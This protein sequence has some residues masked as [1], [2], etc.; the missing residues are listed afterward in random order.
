M[1]RDELL[2]ADGGSVG[3]GVGMSFGDADGAAV[4]D[5]VIGT[6]GLFGKSYALY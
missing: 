1:V 6:L 3:A 4:G 2:C 5:A